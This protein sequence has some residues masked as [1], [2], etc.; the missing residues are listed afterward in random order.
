MSKKYL[1]EYIGTFTLSFVVLAGIIT[2]SGALLL[3]AVPIMAALTVGLFVYTIGPVSGCHLNP[4]V[5]LGLLSVQKIE[6]KEAAGYI[7]AQIVGA[8]CAVI[9]VKVL[10]HANPASSAVLF[11]MRVFLGEMLG[12][13]FLAFGIASVVYG[14]VKELATGIVIGGSLLL[15][16]LIASL[17]GGAGILNPAVAL[18]LN[19]LSIVSIFAPMLGSVLAFHSYRY[20]ATNE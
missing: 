5:T 20:I 3:V 11:D 8:I 13:F 2:S 16:V 10:L 1:A 12:T 6:K 17:G 7:A 14:Q 19:A 4:A 18:T 15:G 9:L